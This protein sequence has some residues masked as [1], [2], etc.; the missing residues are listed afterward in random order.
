ML[1]YYKQIFEKKLYFL[2]FCL[3][4]WSI[5]AQKNYPKNYFGLPVDIPL[6]LAGN[7]GELRPNHFHAGIDIKTQGGQGVRIY[8]IADGVVSRI[9][10]STRGYGKV[11]YIEHPNGYTSVYAHLQKFSPEI[12]AYIKRHQYQKQKYEV[13]LFPQA[14]DFSIKKG[15]LIALS[16]NTG[17]SVAPHLHFEIRDTKTQKS[18]NPRHFGYEVTDQIAPILYRLYGYSLNDQSAI[19]GSQFPVQIPFTKQGNNQFVADKIYADGLIGL[20]VQTIDK[21]NFTNNIYGIYKATISVNG[22]FILSYVFDEM[23]FAEDNYINTLIDYAL[24]FKNSSRIQLMYK[25]DSNKL[26]LYSPTNSNGM[27]DIQE[28]FTYNVVITLED[29]NKN[30]TQIQIP[31]EGK[32]QPITEPLPEPK[33]T[34]LVAL[35]DNYYKTDNGNV[36]FPQQTFYENLYIDVKTQSDTLKVFPNDVPLRKYYN[37]TI[38]NQGKFKENELSQVLIAS[39]NPKN[40]RLAPLSTVRKGNTF[41]TRTKSLGDFVL[42]KDSI[43]PTILPVNFSS[44]K[45]NVSKLASLKVKISDDF[46]GID[47]YTPTING[48]WILMEYEPKEKTLTFDMS[49]M[50][51]TDKELIFRLVVKDNVGN[52]NSVTIP[53][54]L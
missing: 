40:K 52:E 37:L 10:V 47:Q 30:T 11:I 45:N 14:T 43:A 50:I 48:K 33:G 49:D 42:V 32:K 24:Y 51:F 8:S 22:S 29:F 9:K 34:L 17:G 36:F 46:S 54:V 26:S 21:K 38:E 19:N 18:I 25:K 23:N 16:G 12:E 2:V 6:L 44:V 15:D 28:G 41:S 53:L 1:Q 3:L 5:N 31:I 39:V 35:R 4:C 7:F 27:I 20:G 13:E